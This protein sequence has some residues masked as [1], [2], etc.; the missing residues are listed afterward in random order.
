MNIQELRDFLENHQ[1]KIYF[2]TI[3]TSLFI[4]LFFPK[5]S[6]ETLINPA[7]AF[8]LFVTFLQV[9]ISSLVK[10]FKNLRFLFALLISNFVLIPIL[11]LG[12]IQFLPDNFLLKLGVLFVLLTPCV[13]YV[14]TFSHLGKADSK[15][16]LASTPILLI[17]QMLLLPVYIGIFLGEEA[18]LY[19]EIEPF[20]EAF[21]TLI[22]FPFFLAALM[23]VFSRKSVFMEKSSE[24][25]SLFPVISTAFVLFVVIVS[26]IAKF[27]QALNE[28]FY[29]L[30]IYVVFSIFAPIV[31]IL[32]AKVFALKKEEKVALAFSSSTRNSLVILPLALAIPNALPIVPAVI[33]MQT[34]VELFSEIIYIYIFRKYMN[35]A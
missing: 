24:I 34:F 25:L 8:M 1:I 18:A 4:S 6:F 17:V 12:L 19:I 3:F 32:F 11:V 13:D 16:L 7:L 33:V 27:S 26:V 31:A 30:P 23:Q 5:L 22:V 35:K 9:P 28:I 29:A 21:L 10:A 20:L 14:V 15:L 2:F